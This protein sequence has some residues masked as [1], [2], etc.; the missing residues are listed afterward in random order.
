VDSVTIAHSG[1]VARLKEISGKK[2]CQLRVASCVA[3]DAKVMQQ[4]AGG[5]PACPLYLPVRYIHSNCEVAHKN[6]IDAAAA[7]VKYFA[8]ECESKKY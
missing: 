4:S 6:D 7:L 3:N 5:I 2:P 8:A 1:L